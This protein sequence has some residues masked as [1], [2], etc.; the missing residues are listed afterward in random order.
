MELALTAV[1]L[2]RGEALRQALAA[3]GDRARVRE[4]LAGPAGADLDAVRL[5]AA[6]AWFDTPPGGDRWVPQT[7]TLLVVAMEEIGRHPMPGPFQSGLIQGGSVLRALG[8]S[9]LAA[10]AERGAPWTIWC[11]DGADVTA[12]TAP[13]GWRLRGRVPVVADGGIAERLLV[14]VAIE[15]TSSEGVFLVP[16]DAVG[17]S[18]QAVPTIGGD[19]AATIDFDDVTAGPAALVG[20]DSQALGDALDLA[21]VAQCAEM[22]GTAA[23]ALDVAVEYVE[24]RRQWGRGIG[25]FQVIQHGAA[26]GYLD[27]E[28]MRWAVLDAA[29]HRDSGRPLALVASMAKVVCAE[30]VLRVTAWAHQVHGGEGFYAD[31]DPGLFYRRARALA[32]RLGDGRW[33]LARIDALRRSPE[34]EL[35][36]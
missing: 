13:G 29:G 36:P 30:A 25:T 20:D 22:V 17:V 16:A 27:V 34:I 2:A 28:A 32:P 8:Q 24:G 15:S 19:R 4:V 9:T 5:L 33:H 11:G 14:P 35:D 26:D 3:W 31:R 7:L 21:V 18:I 12:R 10:G 6:N 23:A 1:E